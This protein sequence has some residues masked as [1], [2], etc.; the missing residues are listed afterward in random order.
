MPMKPKG[1]FREKTTPVGS[2]S[3]NTFGLY[4]MHGN[5]WEWCQDDWHEY[6]KGAPNNGTA[7]LSQKGNEKVVRGGSWYLI[8]WSCRSACRYWYFPDFRD[9]NIGLRVACD[10]N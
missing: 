8:P 5:V 3:P 2:F 7:W 6:Y 1:N 4:D 9:F 10:S